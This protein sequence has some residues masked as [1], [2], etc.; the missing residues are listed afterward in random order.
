VLFR[1][2]AAAVKNGEWEGAWELEEDLQ[3]KKTKVCVIGDSNSGP[4]HGKQGFYP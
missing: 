4:L 3:Q 1:A 2:T